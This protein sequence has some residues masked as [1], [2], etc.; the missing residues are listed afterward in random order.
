MPDALELLKTR[1]SIKPVELRSRS[2]RGRDRD[3]ADGRLARSRSRQA[4]ALALHRVRRR[5]AACCRR[6]DRRR[7]P[8]QISRRQARAYRRRAHSGWRAR[9]WSSRWSAAPAPH[10]KIPEWEQ[11]LSAGAAAMSLVLAAHALGYGRTGSPNGTPMTAR[12]LDGAR[13]RGER[14]DRGLRPYRPAGD[15]PEDRPRPPL[16]EIA[17]RFAES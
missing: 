9:R 17:T 14:A 7:V 12:V 5:G 11:V 4:R 2:D 10:V 16:A 3:P 8:H 15:P 13:S 6:S 1:R